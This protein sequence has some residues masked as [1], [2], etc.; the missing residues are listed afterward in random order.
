MSLPQGGHPKFLLAQLGHSDI[1]T[2]LGVYGHLFP[3]LGEEMAQSLDSMRTKVLARRRPPEL[4]GQVLEQEKSTDV[5]QSADFVR[6]CRRAGLRSPEPPVA[7]GQG[8]EEHGAH[9]EAILTRQQGVD[10]P[11]HI[12]TECHE[13]PAAF[14]SHLPVRE[15][16]RGGQ[17]PTPLP[18]HPHRPLAD[19]C[20]RAPSLPACGSIL[21]SRIG[22]SKDP[23][24]GSLVHKQV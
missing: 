20:W 2:T 3:S 7:G 23:K 13:P 10:D 18:S 16:L 9:E 4:V 8:P 11:Q 5:A 17:Q 24:V 15:E 1:S 21:H 6:A 19:R 12:A 22:A 14:V